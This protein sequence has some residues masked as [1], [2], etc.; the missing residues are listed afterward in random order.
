M[1]RNTKRSLS[2]PDRLRAAGVDPI[3]VA[4]AQSLVV[5]YSAMRGTNQTLWRD[6]MDLRQQLAAMQAA[7]PSAGGDDADPR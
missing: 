2:L 3:L 5:G 1:G 7:A 4:D 6:N